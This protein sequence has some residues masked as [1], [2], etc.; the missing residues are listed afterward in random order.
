MPDDGDENLLLPIGKSAVV[1]EGTDVTVVANSF[2]VGQCVKVAKHLEKQ[3]ISVE[4][5]DLRTLVP[6]D[7]EAIINSVKKTGR[8][9]IVDEGYTSFGI[10]AEICAAIA[11]RMYRFPSAPHWKSWSFP[12]KTRSSTPSWIWSS[13]GRRQLWQK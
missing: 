13:N 9:L 12:T 1:H 3:G 5:V 11:H 2:Q 6:M 4:V 8:L 7:K 10:A